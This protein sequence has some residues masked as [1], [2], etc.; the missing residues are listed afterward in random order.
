M[1]DA[2]VAFSLS[3]RSWRAVLAKAGLSFFMATV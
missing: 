2:L 3:Q 1:V